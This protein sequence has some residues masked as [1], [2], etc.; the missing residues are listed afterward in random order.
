MACASE[1]GLFNT[2]ISDFTHFPA[3]SKDLFFLMTEYTPVCVCV[4]T[5]MH[6]CMVFSF[7]ILLMGT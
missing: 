3:N 6:T 7:P 5:S 1:S 2:V 4:C